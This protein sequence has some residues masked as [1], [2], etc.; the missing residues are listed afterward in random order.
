MVVSL[1]FKIMWWDTL[2]RNLN[3][4]IGKIKDFS[5]PLQESM[6]EIK[7]NTDKNFDKKTSD[8]AGRWS[9]LSSATLNARANK[10][11]HYR[12]NPS[13]PGILRRTGDLQES[14]KISVTSIM[15]S[16]EYTSP[17]AVYH[18]IWW[19]DVPRRKFLELD[20][21]TKA[22]IVRRFQTYARSSL[23]T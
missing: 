22:N 17:Y 18:Q 16:I 23:V 14:V 1:N 15:W 8:T 3:I 5:T 7:K 11:W 9:Y 21:K 10:R 2:E 20:N 13:N 6:E 19:W 12:K 4:A